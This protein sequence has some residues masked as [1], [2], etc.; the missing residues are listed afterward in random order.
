[1]EQFF[2]RDC[3]VRDYKEV[4]EA[5]VG[6]ALVCERVPK[7]CLRSIAMAVKKEGTIIGRLP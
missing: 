5:A 7:K 6:E 2:E 4:W 1:M 3:C